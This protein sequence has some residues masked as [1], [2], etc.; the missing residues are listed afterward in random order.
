MAMVCAVTES[1][2]Q[3]VNEQWC[4]TNPTLQTFRSKS[5]IMRA[6]SF[7]CLTFLFQFRLLQSGHGLDTP[8]IAEK[9]VEIGVAGGCLSAL[10]ADHETISMAILGRVVL[11]QI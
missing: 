11:F 6:S 8:C 5:F 4:T 10:G 7:I 1:V 2:N 9:T 3:R